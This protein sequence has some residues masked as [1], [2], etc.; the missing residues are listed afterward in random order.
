L[1]LLGFC[2]ASRAVIS[3][4]KLEVSWSH[5]EKRAHQCA[6]FFASAFV[7][8]KSAH[9]CDIFPTAAVFGGEAR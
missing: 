7:R 6:L 1:R 9:E 5:F 2:G 3:L 4:A 8:A